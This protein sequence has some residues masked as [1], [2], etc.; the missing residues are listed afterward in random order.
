MHLPRC[1][2]CH[3]APE[4]CESCAFA[5]IV[6]SV[7][8]DSIFS[9]TEDSPSH[10]SRYEICHEIGRG[11]MG[12]VYCGYDERLRRFVAIKILRNDLPN[13]SRERFADEAKAM[14]SLRHENIVTVYETG[15]HE[16]TPFF[17]MEHIDGEPVSKTSARSPREA[18]RIAWMIA[19][20]M[21]HAHRNGIFHR[22]ITPSNVLIDRN[23]RAFLTDFGLA[24]QAQA[25]SEQTVPGTPFGSPGFMSPEQARGDLTTMIQYTDV[26][27]VGAT[28]YYLLTGTAPFPTNILQETLNSISTSPPQPPMDLNREISP[29]LNT[30]CLKCLQKT[31]SDRYLPEDLVSDLQLY[32]EG[33]PIRARPSTRL[34][35]LIAWSR[36]NKQLATF[37]ASLFGILILTLVTATV[38]ITWK[39]RSEAFSNSEYRRLLTSIEFIQAE[40]QIKLNAV[41]RAFK[42]LREIVARESFD[43]DTS[44]FPRMNAG[45]AAHLRLLSADKYRT[46]LNSIGGVMRQGKTL[47]HLTTDP[48]ESFLATGGQDNDIFV[49]KRDSQSRLA[50]ISHKLGALN[51]MRFISTSNLLIAGSAG[52]V[53]L[54][55]L[56]QPSSKL[57]WDWHGDISRTWARYIQRDKTVI[58]VSESGLVSRLDWFNGTVLN[59]TR[60]TALVT[61]MEFNP[62]RNTVILGAKNGMVWVLDATNF[63]VI[64]RHQ[65]GSLAVSAIAIAGEDGWT[66]CATEDGA[67]SIL[68]PSS[69]GPLAKLSESAGITCLAFAQKASR[70]IIGRQDGVVASIDAT[71]WNPKNRVEL[72]DHDGPV[73]AIAISPTQTLGMSTSADG[74]GVLWNPHSGV[75]VTDPII[76][77]SWI[78]SCVFSGSGEK[79][80]AGYLNGTICTYST[81]PDADSLVIAAVHKQGADAAINCI[82]VGDGFLYA[83]AEGGELLWA[84]QDVR[85]AGSSNHRHSGDGGIQSVWARTDT[86]FTMVG[87]TTGVIQIFDH[88]PS[89]MRTQF[90]AHEGIVWQVEFAP[91]SRQIISRGADN[92]IHIHSLEGQRELTIRPRS[93]ELDSGVELGEMC[94]REDMKGC[95]TVTFVTETETFHHWSS[96]GDQQAVECGTPLQTVDVSPDAEYIALGTKTGTVQ[97]RRRSNMS[98]LAASIDLKEPVFKVRFSSDGRFIL[99]GTTTGSVLRLN[100]LKNLEPQLI[101]RLPGGI[102]WLQSDSNS[103]LAIAASEGGS[104]AAWTLESG[105]QVTEEF[106][107]PEKIYCATVTKDGTRLFT[108][109]NDGKVRQWQLRWPIG[110]ANE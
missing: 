21:C 9:K 92:L 105:F 109:C 10:I 39:W 63:Q 27:G 55:N 70:L 25:S 35:F 103:E 98:E 45:Y 44:V 40:Q 77:D 69:E 73:T 19:D 102:T 42:T 50:V 57:V 81:K 30:I 65:V 33:L 37:I 34:D 7:D 58:T 28:L 67:I 11:G 90:Q 72:V 68:T 31:P 13:P 23:R 83:G 53:V 32:A 59:E 88:T 91:Q 74:T 75:V 49:W 29:D 2:V 1:H 79:I 61:A 85:E 15:V 36:R 108:G 24:K 101:G 82:A 64:S 14:A 26:Y 41:P 20:A 89:K 6:R 78:M 80:Y 16:G 17:V 93:G 5:I 106:K 51:E 96:Q 62:S 4:P 54:L 46:N 8:T 18:A 66:A 104:A 43:R 110:S 56:L 52:G 99:A 3:K 84:E 95:L 38:I 60:L 47:F 87:R 107:H 22:D 71:T 76:A 86:A 100:A 12:I 94:V 48:S 97:L